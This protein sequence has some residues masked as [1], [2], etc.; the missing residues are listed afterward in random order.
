MAAA[1]GLHPVDGA[2][3]DP[4]GR[5]GALHLPLRRVRVRRGAV[6]AHGR[7]AALLAP[8]QQGPGA[9]TMC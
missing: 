5:A 4:H 2:R 1:H 8:Q 6:R 7:R 9:Y 3:G